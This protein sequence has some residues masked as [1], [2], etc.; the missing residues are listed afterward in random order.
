MKHE[1]N[2][3]EET[4]NAYVDNEI[5]SA[6]KIEIRRKAER[7]PEISAQICAT[8]ELK[9]L[10]RDAYQDPPHPVREQS[11]GGSSR[12]RGIQAAAA[13]L[14]LGVGLSAGWL[15]HNAVNGPGRFDDFLQGANIADL[16]DRV[17]EQQNVIVHLASGNP[18]KVGI[19]LDEIEEMANR[20]RA[21]DRK[22]Q[23]EMIVNGEGLNLVR[24][25]SSAYSQRV[26]DILS[27]YDNVTILACRKALELL[28]HKNNVDAQLLQ[29]VMTAPS[30][31]DQIIMRLR[32]GWTYIRV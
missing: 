22:V 13:A 2:L 23:I 25:T 8:R 30:A 20:Y 6:D 12:H 27:R 28:K 11:A 14:L 1:I 9:A 5:G 19:A 26:S 18:T 21:S 31:L 24:K 16:N 4:L 15:A 17:Q 32:E 10:V 3:S 29:G 7:M